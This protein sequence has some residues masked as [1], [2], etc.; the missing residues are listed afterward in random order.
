[1]RPADIPTAIAL[2]DLEDWGCTPG[3]FRR[4]M[5]L[6]PGGCL[7]AVLDGEMVGL[8]T[9]TSYGDVGWIGN[10][11]VHPRH[12][13]KGIGVQLVQ[14]AIEYLEGT[15]AETVRLNSYIHVTFLYGALGFKGEFEN[16]R[17]NGV[18]KPSGDSAPPSSSRFGDVVSFDERYFGCSR[19]RLLWRLRKEFPQSFISTGN[20]DVKGYI[21]GQVEEGSCEIA[22]W[23]VDH[24]SKDCARE[25]WRALAAGVGETRVAFT[26]PVPCEQASSIARWAGLRKGFR[27]LRMYRGRRGH[28]GRPAGTIALGGL[29]KG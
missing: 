14:H 29:E 5:H 15:G 2:T 1:M 18:I 13:G 9:A 21:V 25:L 16:V 7:K 24:R 8:T 11:I 19:R 27:T 10:V 6:D 3:I 28:R 22:P 4:L 17:Y 26:A 20:D 12:R 23:V